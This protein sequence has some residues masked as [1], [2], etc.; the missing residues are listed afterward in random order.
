MDSTKKTQMINDLCRY[1]PGEDGDQR[2]MRL[3]ACV[4]G[5]YDLAVETQKRVAALERK[6]KPPRAPLASQ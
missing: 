3:A 5:T 6:A 4:I 2:W 1:Q